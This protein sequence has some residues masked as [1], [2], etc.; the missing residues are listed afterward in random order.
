MLADRL[1]GI[2]RRHKMVR[3][4]IVS[5]P[6]SIVVETPEENVQNSIV[7]YCGK[8]LLMYHRPRQPVNR[9]GYCLIAIV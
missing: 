3:V 2:N 4:R 9:L 1:K 5:N 7:C 8:L 6:V